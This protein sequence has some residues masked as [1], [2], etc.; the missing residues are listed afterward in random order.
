MEIN[1]CIALTEHKI[2]SRLENPLTNEVILVI[3]DTITATEVNEN[4]VASVFL[5]FLLMD[6]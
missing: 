4:N 1:A 6:K 5:L 2:H 3:I